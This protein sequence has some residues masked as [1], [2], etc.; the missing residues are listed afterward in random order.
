MAYGDARNYGRAHTGTPVVG[1]ASTPDG[2]G[3]WLATAGGGVYGFGDAALFGSLGGRRLV[4]PVVGIAS[5]GDGRGYWLATAG[6]TV[7]GFGDASDHGSPAGLSPAAGPAWTAPVVG[8]TADRAT[9]GYWLVTSTGDVLGYAGAPSYGRA[10]LAEAVVAMAATPDGR[11]GWVVAPD[12]R[13]IP[14]GD[15]GPVADAGSPGAPSGAYAHPVVAMAVAP[16]GNGYWLATSDGHVLAYGDAG[17]VAPPSGS[18]RVA[19]IIAVPPVAAARATGAPPSRLDVSTTSLPALS[20][21]QPYSAQLEASGGTTPYAWSVASGPLP[22][23]LAMSAAGTISGTPEP[24]LSGPFDFS[25]RV[26]DSSAPSPLDATAA[27]TVS[28]VAMA[29]P[30]LTQVPL[31][32]VQSQNWSGYVATAGPYTAAA[33]NFT[34][35][36]LSP[37][38]AGQGMVSEWVG[39][40]GSDNGSLIQAGVTEAPGPPGAGGTDVFAWWEVLPAA[41][42]PI[43]T[44]A[45]R[46][47]DEVGIAIVRLSGSTWAVHLTDGTNGQSYVQDVSYSGPGTSAEW[48]VEAPKDSQ[49]NQQLPLA[50]FSPAVNFSGLSATGNSTATSE[51]VMAQDNQQVSTPSALTSAGFSVVYGG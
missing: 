3:Y 27:L 29:S 24:G 16:G 46:P 7:Y 23:G 20:P 36:S 18:P 47:G 35:P 25:V 40:D 51:V 21:G 15:A 28:T 19:A 48:V 42:Q 5:T 8:I 43:T 26:T 11:G 50:P 41:S 49:T 12:G 1:A 32:L 22:P 17:M 4:S 38:G 39:L 31:S 2:R 33:G 13:T 37:G 10:S 30:A 45:V 9:A 44:V 34:V 6:G 14:L